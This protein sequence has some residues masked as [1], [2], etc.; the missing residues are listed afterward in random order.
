MPVGKTIEWSSRQ[1][2]V[3]RQLHDAG[4]RQCDMAERFGVSLGAV[5]RR[6]RRIGLVA[7][8]PSKRRKDNEAFEA[9]RD[10]LSEHGSVVRAAASARVSRSVGRAWLAQME[11]E[12]GWQAA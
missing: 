4:M 9:F 11:R 12:L 3:L 6:L 5:Q 1:D 8:A 2:A 10:A 7:Q